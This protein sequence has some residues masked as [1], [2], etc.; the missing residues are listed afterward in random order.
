MTL[1]MRMDDLA[2]ETK[3]DAIFGTRAL[4]PLIV[5]AAALFA[6]VSALPAI[7]PARMN[8]LGLISVLPPPFYL[9]LALIAAGFAWQVSYG[10][11]TGP[12]PYLYLIALI[13]VLHA[14]PPL[15]YG[16]L[17]YSWAWK[18][19]G[20]VDYIQRHG[21]VDRTIPFLAA[22]HNW[23]GLFAVTAWVSD[24]FGIRAMDL[25]PIIRFTPLVLTLAL[26]AAGLKLMR[27]LTD[28]P[29]LI[30]TAGWMFVVANWV[31]QDYFSPQGFTFLGYIIL[32]ALFLGPLRKTDTAWAARRPA[33]LAALGPAAPATGH[34]PSHAS[35]MLRALSAILALALI[36]AIVVTHQLTPL[37]VILAAATLAA[38]GWLTPSYLAFVLVAQVIWLLW[39]AAPFVF[40]QVRN[41]LAAIGTLSDATTK[42]ANFETVSA[43]RAWVIL[44]G[45]GLSAAIVLAAFW[46][47][48]RRLLAGFWDLTAVALLLAP[49]PL[50]FVAYGGES[51]FR[52]YLFASPFV[53]FFAAA[54]FFP[55]PRGGRSAFTFL[56]LVAACLLSAIGFLFANNG[57]DREYRFT[58]DTI[59]TARWL[60]S[61]A[62]KGTLLIEGARSYPSQFMNYENFSYLPISEEGDATRKEITA[63]PAGVLSRW[64]DDPRWTDAYIILTRSQQAYLEAGGPMKPGDFDKIED[65][66]LTSPRFRLVRA[67]ENA[68][69]FRLLPETAPGGFGGG[70]R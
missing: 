6:W 44:V 17:R 33:F 61:I 66:L 28:D 56:L 55:S 8:D 13:V 45:R 40:E 37:L 31:G 25:A 4:G 10:R 43:D 7:D 23:P 15:V 67:S 53:A 14:T 34:A 35:G 63:D 20:I 11:A 54:A 22:Y 60:Y 70:P 46:G 9:S 50:L 47:G 39:G 1:P 48:L 19:L 42:L 24:R 2:G 32:L 49:M 30:V 18:H 52:V 38:L 64:M 58:P 26:V 21:T 16:T 59:K 12:W 36:L 69:V 65:A 57:K 3:A 29:R 27:R 41:E 51:V 68:K 62:P 5:L